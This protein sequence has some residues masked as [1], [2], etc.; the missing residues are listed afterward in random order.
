MKADYLFY[1]LNKRMI[2]FAEMPRTRGEWFKV[3]LN[4]HRHICI[5]SITQNYDGSIVIPQNL[6]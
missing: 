5:A 2:S 4:R 6:L 1:G 3:L